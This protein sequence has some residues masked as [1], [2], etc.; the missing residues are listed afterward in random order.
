MIFNPDASYVIEKG[1][2]LI[3]MGEDVNL[4]KFSEVCS[5]KAMNV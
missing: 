4:L 5:S 1:D 2:I 3:T